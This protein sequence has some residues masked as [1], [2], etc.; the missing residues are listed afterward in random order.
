M[1]TTSDFDPHRG[2]VAWA[3][4]HPSLIAACDSDYLLDIAIRKI[5]GDRDHFPVAGIGTARCFA[6]MRFADELCWNYAKAARRN[7][8][9]PQ[10]VFDALNSEIMPYVRF[11][12]LTKD[13]H[14][15]DSRLSLLF[16][17]D[18]DDLDLG[19]L[20]LLLAPCHVL[21]LDKHLRHS[22]LARLLESS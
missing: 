17:A 14:C 10:A 21:S 16:E 15:N 11:V 22:K 13:F 4:R 19:R 18:Q 2:L 5:L 3:G 6:P 8:V 7:G 9:E 20:A 12:E 1:V